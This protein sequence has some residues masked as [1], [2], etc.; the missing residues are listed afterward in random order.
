VRVNTLGGVRPGTVDISAG[1]GTLAAVLGHCRVLD[2]RNI[3]CGP[4]PRFPL[5]RP[6]YACALYWI[7][8]TLED[9]TPPGGEGNYEQ[10][11]TYNCTT[12][13]RP[14]LSCESTMLE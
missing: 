6:R 1:A 10:R 9:F 4:L 12:M 14:C 3:V 13:G 8:C 11:L 5:L 2:M 7:P